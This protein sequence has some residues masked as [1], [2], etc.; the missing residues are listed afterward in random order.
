MVVVH[1]S[2]LVRDAA[3]QADAGD[4]KLAGAEAVELGELVGVALEEQRGVV[5]RAVPAR[6]VVVVRHEVVVE[7]V[8]AAHADEEDAA[9]QVRRHLRGVAAELRRVPH[10]AHRRPEV[11]H[12]LRQR[13]VPALPIATSII[14]LL[15]DDQLYRNALQQLVCLHTDQVVSCLGEDAGGPR[16]EVDA[17]GEVLGPRR[18][19]GREERRAEAEHVGEEVDHGAAVGEAPRRA[20]VEVDAVG[21]VVG[22]GQAQDVVVVAVVHQRVAEDVH[23][24]RQRRLLLLP[25]PR[26]RAAARA[27]HSC[28]H[29]HGERQPPVVVHLISSP[30]TGDL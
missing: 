17:A 5:A 14:K 11:V 26:R 18:G 13:V 24:R 1:P 20:L 28:H 27:R 4:D 19:V 22:T 25:A 3:D 10:V 12:L 23:A 16:R 21:A 8:V 15:I 6:G 30:A 7:V 29:R 2:E 9:A